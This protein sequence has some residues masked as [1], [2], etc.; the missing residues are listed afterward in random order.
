[1]S[2]GPL[3]GQTSGTPIALLLALL[4]VVTGLGLDP[5]NGGAFLLLGF[6]AGYPWLMRWTPVD[7]GGADLG[8]GYLDI[9]D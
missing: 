1:M 5:W 8:H 2:S 7:D 9:L 6:G 4:A 3:A